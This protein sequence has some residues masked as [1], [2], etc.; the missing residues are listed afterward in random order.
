MSNVV[1]LPAISHIYRD[2][3]YTI[4]QRDNSF[5]WRFMARSFNLPVGE[6]PFGGNANTMSDAHNKCKH[7]ID[8]IYETLRGPHVRN[9]QHV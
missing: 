3:P 2:I 8:V 6:L 4:H 5:H 1:Q 9:P 7:R